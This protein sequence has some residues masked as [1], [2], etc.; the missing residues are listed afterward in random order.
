MFGEERKNLDF[1]EEP[2]ADFGRESCFQLG[3]RGE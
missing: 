1:D 3:E 2:Q